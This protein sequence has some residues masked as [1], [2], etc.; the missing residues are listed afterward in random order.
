M[1]T[2]EIKRAVRNLKVG[3][4]FYYTGDAANGSSWGTVLGRTED[5]GLFFSVAYDDTRFEG[6]TRTSRRVGSYDFHPG[7]GQ[8]FKVEAQYRAEQAVMMERLKKFINR[9]R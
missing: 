5:Q 6:D 2:E 9:N 4:R 8:R 7:P 3:D 1:T